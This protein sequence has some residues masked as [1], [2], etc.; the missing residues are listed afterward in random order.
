MTIMS[1][2]VKVSFKYTVLE[3][4]NFKA[5]GHFLNSVS[6]MYPDFSIWLNFTFRRGLSSGQRKIVLA[7]YGDQVVGVALLKKNT[8]ESK[9]CTFYIAPN[10]REMG[11]GGDLMD[12]ALETLDSQSTLITVSDER[13]KQLA[14]LLSSRGFMLINS[15]D[16]LYRPSS[17]E[18]F[19]SL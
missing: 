1:A 9:I 3:N 8:L 4:A 10:F 7:H 19:Y 5:L 16:G 13:Q 15:V 12:I 6:P 11:I 18:H 17:S 2:L 14:P